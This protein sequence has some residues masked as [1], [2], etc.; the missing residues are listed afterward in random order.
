MTP[1]V[2]G[3]E[4][5]RRIAELLRSRPFSV[6]ELTVRFAV[7]P[8]TIRRDLASLTGS[9]TIVRTYG[10]AATITPHETS[11]REREAIA[12]PQKQ[13]IA[14]LAASFVGDG[15]RVILD[16]GTTVA[17]L[18]RNLVSVADLRVIT[19]SI[20]AAR[21]LEGSEQV[22]VVLLGGTLRHLSSAT[23]GPLAEGVL[24]DLTVDAA[25]LGG[26]GLTAERGIVEQDQQQ[27][28][29]KRRMIDAARETFVLIDSSKLGRPGP[30][31]WARLTPPWHLVTDAG[32]LED[33]LRPFRSLPG[34][35]VHV[36]EVESRDTPYAER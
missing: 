13:A 26:D 17:A 10:G 21:V 34:V 20:T 31:W 36:A 27:V 1:E 12:A 18:A 11:L 6:E 15:A 7:S 14:R 22:E 35:A 29:L 9:R 30:G 23:V 2:S 28:S 32:A 24:R 16:A 25:F 4:R 33:D 19:S 3:P 8:S 5:R